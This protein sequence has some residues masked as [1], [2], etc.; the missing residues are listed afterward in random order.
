VETALEGG[1]AEEVEL[2]EGDALDG[3]KLLGVDRPIGGDG[4]VAEVGEGV[5]LLEADDGEFRSGE[6]VF[7]GVLGGA[8]FALG[9]AGS[10]GVLGIG[11]ISSDFLRGRPGVRHTTA[12]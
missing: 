12:V 8:G 1:A 6:P 5:E 4:V 10:G 9:G 2:S 3:E 7:A 11:A